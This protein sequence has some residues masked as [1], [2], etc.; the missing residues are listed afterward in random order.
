MYE[1]IENRNINDSHRR[2]DWKSLLYISNGRCSGVHLYLQPLTPHQA[3]T[4]NVF[5][6]KY[7]LFD[8]LST[9]YCKALCTNV[10]LCCIPFLSGLVMFKEK[11]FLIKLLNSNINIW[12]ENYIWSILNEKKWG[13]NYRIFRDTIVTHKGVFDEVKVCSTHSALKKYN[14]WRLMP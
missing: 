12:F 3:S 5:S 13:S 2:L 11:S 4:L 1:G 8:S 9:V 10:Q 7:L 14:T 6:I